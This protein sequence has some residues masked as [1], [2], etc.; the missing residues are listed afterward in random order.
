MS[1]YVR[2]A[3][4]GEFSILTALS[5]IMMLSWWTVMIYNDEMYFASINDIELF[6]FTQKKKKTS[7]HVYAAKR[8]LPR[9]SSKIRDESDCECGY[10]HGSHNTRLRA[11]YLF[12]LRPRPK[13]RSQ[14]NNDIGRALRDTI[15]LIGQ[16]SIPL[17]RRCAAR[18]REGECTINFA[19]SAG[20]E[21]RDDG[22][23]VVEN[24]RRR[25]FFMLHRAWII[26]RSW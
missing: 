15:S 2:C 16:V 17:T 22:T 8:R 12:K 13:W 18:R 4:Y 19:K 6:N 26:H 21:G 25:R 3:I 20:G 11:A 10:F 7:T 14:R 1:E 23:I 24:T 9:C 5:L